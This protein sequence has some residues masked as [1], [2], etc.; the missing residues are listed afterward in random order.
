MEEE[1]YES[2]CGKYTNP[3]YDKLWLGSKKKRTKD[4][5]LLYI[6][7]LEKANEYLENKLSAIN[8]ECCQTRQDHYICKEQWKKDWDELNEWERDLY[9]TGYL[10][11]ADDINGYY[12][13]GVWE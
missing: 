4:E 3:K 11:C 13:D 8:H 12:Y 10:H 7:E 9:Y 5:L 6:E 2:R 1:T